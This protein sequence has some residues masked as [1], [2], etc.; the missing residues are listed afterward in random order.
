[1]TLLS[2]PLCSNKN[3]THTHTRSLSGLNPVWPLNPSPTHSRYVYMFGSTVRHIECHSKP[4]SLKGEVIKPSNTQSA[5][6]QTYKHTPLLLHTTVLQTSILCSYFQRISTKLP[7]TDICAHMTESEVTSVLPDWAVF[8]PVGPLWV[9]LCGLKWAWMGGENLGWFSESWVVFFKYIKNTS[10]YNITIFIICTPYLHEHIQSLST[11]LIWR[12]FYSLYWEEICSHQI[13]IFITTETTCSITTSLFIWLFGSIGLRVLLFHPL[14]VCVHFNLAYSQGL[15]QL[16]KIDQTYY[17]CYVS[18]PFIY[19]F[20]YLFSEGEGRKGKYFL[21]AL[22]NVTSYLR[23]SP[24]FNCCFNIMSYWKIVMNHSIIV[25][26]LICIV[27]L[28]F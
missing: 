19:S 4:V 5:S 9:A 7:L 27:L 11:A 18:C 20:I 24:L 17:F 3:N 15:L 22:Y 16:T 14:P 12:S 21:V 6:L 2:C 8:C 1:M 28:L 26:E 10:I 13:C 25:W 23:S